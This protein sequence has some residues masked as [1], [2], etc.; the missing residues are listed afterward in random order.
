MYLEKKNVLSFFD[1]FRYCMGQLN[2]L[3]NLFIHKKIF[4]GL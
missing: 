4:K 1:D 2:I 3:M